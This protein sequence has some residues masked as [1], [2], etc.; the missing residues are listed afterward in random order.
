VEA[1]P[2]S[3]WIFRYYEPV[4]DDLGDGE[5]QTIPEFAEQ[6]REFVLTVRDHVCGASALRKKNF[7]VYLVAH[8]MGGLIAR[9]YLQNICVYGVPV[10]K[11]VNKTQQ[12]KRNIELELP[13][14]HLV[15]KVYTYATPHNGIDVK[16]FNVPD[17]GGLDKLHVRN[18]NRDVIWDYLKLGGNGPK[19]KKRPRGG[20]VQSLNN[21][22]PPERFFCLV[23]TNHRDYHA[24]KDLSRRGTG[25]RSDGLV[26]IHNAW[27]D[28]APRAYVH[29]SHSGHYGI[30]N[31]EEGYQN[32]RRFL[33]GQISMSVQLRI[34]QFKL[35]KHIEKALENKETVRALY[36]VESGVCV[37]GA[38]YYLHERRTAHDSETVRKDEDF[39]SRKTADKIFLFSGF[40]HEKCKSKPRK[41]SVMKG[42]TTDDAALAFAVD[43]SVQMP[44]IEIEKKWWPDQHF[45]VQTLLKEQVFFDVT[46]TQPVSM[47]Y[48]YN[49]EDLGSA[50]ELE[51][52]IIPPKDKDSER[53]LEYEVP[54]GLY[55]NP[56]PDTYIQ[57]TLIISGQN[58][59][60][61]PLSQP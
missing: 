2:R 18:F 21:A 10:K 54:V 11:G 48:R 22:F 35:P 49:L 41:N 27:V 36:R 15:D 24:F 26:M 7:R 9:C 25:E 3:I 30:V 32:L 17:L 53:T 38:A 46:L 45:Q 12:K 4:S 60:T 42:L 31:S 16:G 43:L 8:S 40:L 47:K 59:N 39:Q 34:D 6:L 56:Q 52:K 55:V 5:R 50:E 20:R 19:P 57:G 13:G 37:R 23:G 28:G 1:S 14:K 61:R 51:A 58:W 29:R 33:F 44:E